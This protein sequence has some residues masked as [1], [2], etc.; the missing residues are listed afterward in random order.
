[1]KVESRDNELAGGM[2]DEREE[3]EPTGRHEDRAGEHADNAEVKRNT[4]MNMNIHD[5][6][7]S[8]LYKRLFS[9]T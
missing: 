1:V 5:E 9:Q 6:Q 8:S 3:D 4:S 7:L 2:E